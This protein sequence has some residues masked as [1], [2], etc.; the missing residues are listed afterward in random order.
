MSSNEH[1][2]KESLEGGHIPL[3]Y[4]SDELCPLLVERRRR[5][6]IN[7]KI[8][9]L[10]TL[11]PRNMEG[12]SSDISGKD[13]RVNK[14]TILKGTVDYV[15]ELKQELSALKHNGELLVAIKNE[16]IILQ[17]KLRPKTDQQQQ[18][19][20]PTKQGIVRVKFYLYVEMSEN[21]LQLENHLKRLQNL[22]KE[23]THIKDT[24]WQYDSIDK[25]SA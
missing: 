12:S 14:G 19:A 7:D 3:R 21:N 2:P 22:R 16:N 24:D 1:T 8:K 20:A 9:E 4:P 5:F 23:L 17:H 11:L 13:G 15:K 25:F 6:N 18:Q 10:G